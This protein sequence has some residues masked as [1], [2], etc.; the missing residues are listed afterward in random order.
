MNLSLVWK[1]SE[2][3]VCKEVKTLTIGNRLI[4]RKLLRQP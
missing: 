2:S 1:E 3:V 4:A